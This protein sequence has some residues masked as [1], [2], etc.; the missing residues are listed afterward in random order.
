MS[1]EVSIHDEIPTLKSVYAEYLVMTLGEY[2]C[3]V[4]WFL[5]EK[6]IKEMIKQLQLGLQEMH[7]LQ[8]EEIEKLAKV[9][10]Q[11][12]HPEPVSEEEAFNDDEVP[13]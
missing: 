3:E 4:T 10:P 11:E 12:V 1:L 13:F 7:D 9:Q 2:P 6:N 8:E 5:R